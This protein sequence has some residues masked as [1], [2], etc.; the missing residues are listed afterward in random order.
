M[1]KNVFNYLG[2]ILFGLASIVYFIPADSWLFTSELIDV[3]INM[4]LRYLIIGPIAYAIAFNMFKRV[5]PSG[6]WYAIIAAAFIYLAFLLILN[7]LTYKLFPESTIPAIEFFQSIELTWKLASNVFLGIVGVS[8]IRITQ[9]GTPGQQ[10]W[11]SVLGLI[12]QPAW[13]YIAYADKN[14]GIFVL[15]LFYTEAWVRGFKKHWID[16]RN[17]VTE[18]KE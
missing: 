5:R 2:W 11:A 10:K 4:E 3:I 12:G 8:A 14:W 1:F 17:P 6:F 9:A 7:A 13:F 18:T 15:C 16:N